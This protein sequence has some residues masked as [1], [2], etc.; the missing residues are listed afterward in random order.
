MPCLDAIIVILARPT[1]PCIH[2]VNT[3]VCQLLR[4]YHV[5]ACMYVC[6]YACM[7]VC[8]YVCMLVIAL[9]G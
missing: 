2:L 9:Y 3:I 6:M 8:M 5:S 1:M 4:P 7:Y